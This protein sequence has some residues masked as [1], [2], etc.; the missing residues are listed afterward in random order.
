MKL[1]VLDGVTLNPGDLSWD[2]LEALGECTVHDRTQPGKVLARAGGDEIV[3]TNKVVLSAALLQ[4]LPD[5]KYI[6]VLATGTNV[7][8][9][10]AAAR[11]D[12]VVT[13][14]P[15]YS[16]ASVA[17][18]TFALLLELTLHVGSHSEGV[19]AGRWS[20]AKDFSYAD[21][22]LIELEGLTLGIV[23][24]GRIGQRVAAIARSFG[25]TVL[26][27]SRTQPGPE[28]VGVRAV[29]LDTLFCESDVVTLHCPLTEGTTGLVNAERLAGMK[30]SAFLINTG[31]GPLIDESALAEALNA[32]TIAG[33]AVDVLSSEPPPVENPLL[34]AQNCLITPHI[35]WATLAA[36]RTLMEIVV[37]NV[38]AFLQGAPQNVVRGH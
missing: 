13:N 19:R 1:V 26:V 5:L 18:L 37:T 22:P 25:M 23:G 30:S 16:T 28:K 21:F 33:A 38:T 29:D 14:V 7:V 34:S 3:L 2:P 4:Q 32:R 8:D 12:I 17:Q 9:L 27:H 10:Q 11:Q 36:R 20:Q 35:G 6:G 15:D 31:R 24:F